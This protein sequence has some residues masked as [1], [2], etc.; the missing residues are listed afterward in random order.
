P[1]KVRL[2]AAQVAAALNGRVT[3]PAA[4]RAFSN[5]FYVELP[6]SNAQTFRD[7]LLNQNEAGNRQRFSSGGAAAF[8]SLEA[9][10]LGLAGPTATNQPTTVLEIRVVEPAK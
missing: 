4:T 10:P 5:S 7:R 8:K 3:E 2:E 6:A 1:N 9:P